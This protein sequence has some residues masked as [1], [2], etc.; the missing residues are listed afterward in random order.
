MTGHMHADSIV[1][2]W[3]GA[4]SPLRLADGIANVVDTVFRNMRLYVEIADVSFTGVVRF[5]N[6]AL[7]NVTLVQGSIVSTTLNDNEVDPLWGV[8]YHADDDA[9]YDV[10]LTPV[11]VGRRGL[12][13][14]EFV[15]EEDVMSDCLFRDTPWGVALP[16]CP[17]E[18][19]Q[20]RAELFNETEQDEFYVDP[21]ISAFEL[22]DDRLLSDT[23][24]WLVA[25]R[26]AL[27]PLPPP[28][29]GWPPFNVT[30]PEKPDT[31]RGITMQLPTSPGLWTS[32]Q[33]LPA[34]ASRPVDTYVAD[35]ARP[36][37]LHSVVAVIVV[38]AVIA[39]AG[40]LWAVRALRRLQAAGPPG[41]GAG[42]LS[43]RRP[44]LPAWMSDGAEQVRF[45]PPRAVK[46]TRYRAAATDCRAARTHACSAGI[47]HGGGKQRCIT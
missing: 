43:R 7:A 41:H 3:S 14:A 45:A 8:R 29:P 5:Q 13:G 27:G 24:P 2:D 23:A 38:M 11:P 25:V 26:T 12:F 42:S 31:H 16:G 18:S 36:Y 47:S 9:N 1:T 30:P 6:A 37:G 10:E 17:P 19:A 15:I 33:T 21:L 35:P 28:P 32:F 22:Y 44:R 20:K 46:S 4:Q 39:L 34:P 40:T